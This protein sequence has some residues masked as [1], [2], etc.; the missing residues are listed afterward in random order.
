ML[1]ANVDGIRITSGTNNTVQAN[2]CLANTEYGIKITDSG[3]IGN[4]IRHNNLN[5]NANPLTDAGVTTTIKYNIGYVTEGSG[6][7]INSTATTF[8][9][10]HGLSVTPDVV[11]CSF[12]STEITA[13]TWTATSTQITVTVV[14]MIA[15]RTCYWS[16][17]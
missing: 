10:N 13:Y 1:I 16:V 7:A 5:F 17:P 11:L 8:V 9:F 15:N 2:T 12:D 6:S 3:A 4:I 14:G